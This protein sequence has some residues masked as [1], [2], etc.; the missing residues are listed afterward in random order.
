MSL[1]DRKTYI[2]GSDVP[3]LMGLSPFKK[4]QDLLLE[5]LGLKEPFAGNVHTNFG[6]ELE[7]SL[8]L[9]YELNNN[10]EITNR[11]EKLKSEL[12]G[13]ALIGH[14]D[15]RIDGKTIIDFKTAT[16]KSKDDWQN[17]VPDYY[18][19][20]ALFYMA[21]DK[22]E[23]FIFHVGFINKYD[24]SGKLIEP[25]NWT[26][27]S[28]ETHTC[29]YDEIKAQKMFRY[30]YQFIQ[31]IQN[32]NTGLSK[33]LKTLDS[34][35]QIKLFNDLKLLEQIESYQKELK[36]KILAEMEQNGIKKLSN[37]YFEITYVEQSSRK[38]SINEKLLIESGI[39]IE[40]FRKPESQ[41]KSSIR[42]KLK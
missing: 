17:G 41:I 22:S 30:I 16:I 5:K 2:G 14:I 19:Y 27:E 21:L 23:D 3:V 33:E 37:D 6:S 29:K 32:E 25:E 12:N 35:T 34:E 24:E 26:I 11:Q 9:S 42:I 8:A 40:K 10:C 18:Y 38:G 36:A 4:R 20:Q 7:D 39:D 28:H 1:G 13:F 31:D 15:G